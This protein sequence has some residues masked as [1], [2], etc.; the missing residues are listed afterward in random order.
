MAYIRQIG[1]N[2]I[3]L[4]DIKELEKHPCLETGL[5]EI[6]NEDIPKDAEF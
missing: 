6:V 2:T 4:T 1:T 5:F 3:V